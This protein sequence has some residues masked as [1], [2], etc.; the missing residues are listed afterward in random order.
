MR[1]KVGV[2]LVDERRQVTLWRLPQDVEF[3]VVIVVNNAVAHPN[4]KLP[5]EVRKL[6]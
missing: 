1:G 6:F 5:R 2:Q 3:H 4:R